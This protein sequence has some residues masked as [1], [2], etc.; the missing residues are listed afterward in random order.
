M[1]II[2]LQPEHE[3]LYFQCLED[4]SDE[5]REAGS[6][7]EH[8]YRRMKGQGL[9]VKLAL[10]DAGTVGGMIQYLP[11]EHS[12][13]RGKGL[14]FVYCIWVHGYPKGRGNFQKRGMGTALLEAAEEDARCLGAT[15]MAAWGLAL[16]FWM[17]AAWFRRHGYVPADRS[18][19]MMLLWKRFDDN[20]EPPHWIRKKKVPVPQPGRVTVSA[21]INGWC[22]AQNMAIERARRAAEQLGDRVAFEEYHTWD[23]AVFEE[24]GISDG[25][26]IDGR[27]V[28]T[29]PPPSYD[30]LRGLIAKRLRKLAS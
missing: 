12:D 15:G 3:T 18:G 8:W 5:I 22:P 9:R 27:E 20:A 11:I 30:R 29:G 2:D 28:R 23:R 14:Y 17:R 7:K 19:M 24:W 1:R 25:L 16:P 13:V 6:H 26:Y 4:W 21:F 10:D